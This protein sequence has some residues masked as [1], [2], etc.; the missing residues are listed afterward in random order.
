ME[1]RR[2]GGLEKNTKEE[3]KVGRDG[4]GGGEVMTE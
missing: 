4:R 2:E 1:G 3:R